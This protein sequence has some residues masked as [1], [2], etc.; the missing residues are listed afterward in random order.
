M[1]ESVDRLD[2]VVYCKYCNLHRIIHLSERRRLLDA[3]MT[4]KY[5]YDTMSRCSVQ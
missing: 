1:H 4:S 5:V 2:N 3:R